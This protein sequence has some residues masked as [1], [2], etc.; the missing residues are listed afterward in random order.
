VTEPSPT[1]VR[2][3]PT[4]WL[5]KRLV[6]GVLLVLTSVLLG[7]RVL[8]AADDAQQVWAATRDLA[9]GTVIADG[10]L[11][12]SR[13]RL[14]DSSGH[15]LAG[16]KPLGYVVQRS[17]SREELVPLTALSAPGKEVPRREVTVPVLTGHLPPDL[18]RGE[19]VDLYVSP[20]D[21][22]GRARLVLAGLTVAD[23]VSGDGLG[24]TGQEQPVVLEVAP[25][26]V[27]VLVQAL[28]AGR[29]DLV[30]VPPGQQGPLTPA[31]QGP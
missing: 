10:D 8:A 11:S 3:A 6:F 9:A 27:L 7:A 4:S 30:R 18:V 13:V 19:Q 1:A 21:K 20:G 31:R 28:S 15:Y 24:A 14:F 23:V 22:G 17:V 29:V 5:D 16:A 12:L 26:Q 25:S 2:I